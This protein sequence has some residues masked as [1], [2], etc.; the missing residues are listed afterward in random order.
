MCV[1]YVLTKHTKWKYW[2]EGIDTQNIN[3]GNIW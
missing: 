2:T 3:A 1:I